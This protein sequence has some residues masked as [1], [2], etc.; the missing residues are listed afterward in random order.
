[1]GADT[2]GAN[3]PSGKVTGVNGGWTLPVPFKI[4][5]SKVSG[6]QLARFTLVAK[7]NRSAAYDISNFYVDPRMHR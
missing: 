4:H 1:M 2:W 6:W 5:P 7:G 3:Q